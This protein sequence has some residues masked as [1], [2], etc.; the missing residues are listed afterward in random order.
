MSRAYCVAPA[1]E[2]QLKL[3]YL[4]DKRVKVK[5]LA[6]EPKPV[7]PKLP[8]AVHVGDDHL[9][10]LQH[11]FAEYLKDPTPSSRRW[12][13]EVIEHPHDIF[14][15]KYLYPGDDTSHIMSS[16]LNLVSCMAE[17]LGEGLNFEAYDDNLARYF[18]L[19]EGSCMELYK[20]ARDIEVCSRVERVMVVL[21]MLRQSV[22]DSPAPR[23]ELFG[24]FDAHGELGDLYA[25]L[26][27]S[28]SDTDYA[29]EEEEDSDSEDEGPADADGDDEE[30]ED[31]G[32]GY[33]YR[34]FYRRLAVP[35]SPAETPGDDASGWSESEAERSGKRGRGGEEV[36]APTAA[37]EERP[38]CAPVP[39]SPKKPRTD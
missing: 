39:S 26:D 36:A 8:D 37:G 11:L 2:Q 20:N 18:G 6:V 1:R 22:R 31:D 9:A 35:A 24:A 27:G 4:G 33:R 29:P 38:D 30:E 21:V 14:M 32:T 16:L 7:R 17:R 19:E 28:D 34:F 25:L 5:A 10:Y 23:A 13:Y 12:I 15:P 3:K